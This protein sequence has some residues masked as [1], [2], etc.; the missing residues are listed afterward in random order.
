MK[1]PL[2]AA[3]CCAS[4]LGATAATAQAA[5]GSAGDAASKSAP[6][7]PA[8][9]LAQGSTG[10]TL[11]K[12]DRSLSG[13]GPSAKEAPSG[14]DRQRPASAIAGR[15]EWTQNCQFGLYRGT[16]EMHQAGANR[17]QGTVYQRSPEASGTIVEGRFRANRVSFKVTLSHG[18]ETF[19]GSL[20]G[21]GRLQGT[22]SSQYGP[23]TWTASRD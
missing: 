20:A 9:R 18:V 22:S 14:H 11:G 12:R 15:W 4:L 16:F 1:L 21:P 23:C 6:V 19:D 13:G 7:R 17:V 5:S 8:V 2:A 3:V 10:G